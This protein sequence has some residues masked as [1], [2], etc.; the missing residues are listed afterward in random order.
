MS[1]LSEVQ[2]DLYLE[3]MQLREILKLSTTENKKL[4][5]LN[6]KQQ[7]MIDD[8]EANIAYERLMKK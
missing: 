1:I 7:E 4:R 5:E 3:I 2:E 8:L 6:T